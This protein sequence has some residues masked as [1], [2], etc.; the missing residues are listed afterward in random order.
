MDQR[1]NIQNTINFEFLCRQIK[2]R[3]KF[4]NFFMRYKYF[5]AD[6]MMFL[7][8]SCWFLLFNFDIQSQHHKRHHKSALALA[9][10]SECAIHQQN[11]LSRN[12]KCASVA[13]NS[14]NNTNRTRRQMFLSRCSILIILLA[15]FQSEVS[16]L[17]ILIAEIFM[18]DNKISL[19][20]SVM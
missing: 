3:I 7:F 14:D 4:V 19:N 20:G 15:I 16:C 6:W 13:Q 12:R 8:S 1:R 2:N 18:F 10:L 9:R 11:Y 17:L 5:I